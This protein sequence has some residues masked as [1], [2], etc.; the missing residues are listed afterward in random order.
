MI[1]GYGTLEELLEVITW[2]QL[3]IHDKPVLLFIFIPNPKT[4]WPIIKGGA[5]CG[6]HFAGRFAER[7]RILQL[8]AHVHRHRSRGGLHQPQRSPHHRVC[9]D[10]Q[11]ACQEARGNK[12]LILILITND[13]VS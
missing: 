2:A 4:K 11:R 9:T 5:I 8:V 10:T 12:S 1:G 13:L 7:R 3:G 6:T